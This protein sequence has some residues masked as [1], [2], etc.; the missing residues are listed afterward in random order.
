MAAEGVRILVRE[1]SIFSVDFEK[2]LAALKSDEARA[3]EMEHGIRHE[4]HVRLEEDPAFYVSLR[5][6][7]EKIIEDRKAQRISAARQLEL[8]DGLVKE[9]RGHD[10]IAHEAGL[11]ETGFAIYGLL[12]GSVRDG[13]VAE[14]QVPYGELDEP[15]KALVEVLEETVADDVRIIDDVQRDMRRRIK[16]QLAV[17]RY[18]PRRSGGD[19]LG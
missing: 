10:E 19:R 18:E 8:F 3:S 9:V 2:K 17:A 16:R 4:I 1:V 5:E 7:L 6:R 15:R 14:P 13:E 11:S 12:A